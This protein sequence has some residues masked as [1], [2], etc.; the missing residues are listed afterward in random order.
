MIGQNQNNNM[1]LIIYHFFSFPFPLNFTDGK[2]W[3][4]T[5]DCQCYHFKANL[6]NYIVNIY[7]RLTYFPNIWANLAQI[8]KFKGS[9]D[10]IKFRWLNWYKWQN[11]RSILNFYPFFLFNY[12]IIIILMQL[13]DYLYCTLHMIL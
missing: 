11:S 4:E 12:L 6:S 5:I 3:K 7:N 9:L 1:A 8:C 2:K 10:K 13:L